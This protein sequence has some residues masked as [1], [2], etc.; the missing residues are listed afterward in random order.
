MAQSAEEILCEESTEN[1]FVKLKWNR[2]NNDLN[3][4]KHVHKTRQEFLKVKLLRNVHHQNRIYWT[5]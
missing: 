5:L 2:E 1:E 3:N 4:L